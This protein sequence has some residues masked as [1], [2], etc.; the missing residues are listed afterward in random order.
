[1][2][3]VL[4]CLYIDGSR[5]VVTRTVVTRTVVTQTVA[6]RTVVTL[7]VVT[8]TVVT[9]DNK[10]N[11]SSSQVKKNCVIIPSEAKP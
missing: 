8:R 3:K 1:M 4:R 6:T 11:V 5:A 7:T 10:N 9:P 2:V